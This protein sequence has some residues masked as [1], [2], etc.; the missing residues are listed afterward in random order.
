MSSMHHH[1]TRAAASYGRRRAGGA[2]NVCRA[3]K[4]KCDN[5]RPTCGFCL[6]T[7]GHCSYQD[8]SLDCSRL[9]RG[10]LAIL[11]RISEL[12]HNMGRLL[13]SA[14]IPPPPQQVTCPQYVERN[15][16]AQE[17]P[18]R[19]VSLEAQQ[20]GVPPGQWEWGDIDMPPSNEAIRAST[21]M[22]IEGML[23]WPELQVYRESAAPLIATLG[24]RQTQTAAESDMPYDDDE[25][26]D[27]EAETLHHLVANFLSNNHTKNPIFDVES[28]WAH[29]RA[30]SAEDGP[31]WDGRSC[32]IVSKEKSRTSSIRGYKL[33][34]SCI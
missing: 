34:R 16:S 8:E 7:G 31:G 3:R 6:A 20:Q 9:D 14:T 18:P 2:C 24:Q 21:D 27:V 25:I 1:H 33:P 17:P 26:L 23:R 30:F 10:S 32:L 28:L 12:E 22:T 15:T 4:T 5:Q 13:S 29:T 19:H 11:Q